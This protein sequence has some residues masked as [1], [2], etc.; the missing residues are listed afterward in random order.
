MDV[1]RAGEGQAAR[2]TLPEVRCSP[3]EGHHQSQGADVTTKGFRV[4]LDMR[5]CKTWAHK[6][7]SCKHLTL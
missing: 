5:R 7:F 2:H 4:F 1:R 3:P 6:I